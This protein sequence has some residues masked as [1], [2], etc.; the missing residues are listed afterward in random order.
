MDIKT[1]LKH[2]W[3][4]VVLMLLILAYQNARNQLQLGQF[5]TKLPFNIQTPTNVEHKNSVNSKDN[6]GTKKKR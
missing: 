6:K 4:K 2:N 5:I 1:L 3:V